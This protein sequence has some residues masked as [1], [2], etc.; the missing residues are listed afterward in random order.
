M[1]TAGIDMGAKTVKVVILKDGKV[2]AKSLV[3]AGREK[4]KYAQDAFDEALKQGGISS[5]DVQHITATGV[6]RKRVP[7]ANDDVTAVSADIKG[8]NSLVPSARTVIDV[9]AE[10]GRAIRC[11]AN[12]K[13]IDFAVNE[14]CAAGAGTFVETLARTMEI[15]LEDAGELSL[16]ST[17][18]IEM[19]AQCAVFGESEM[20]SLVHQKVPK[21][22]IIHAVHDAIASR[23]GSLV[24]TIEV[25][26]DI[27]VIGGVARN[28]GF[29][30]SLK[31][32]LGLDVIV[33][34][35]P[36]FAGALGAALIAA[37]GAPIE[38][39]DI[40]GKVV[41]RED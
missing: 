14:K 23:I 2:L 29:I 17:Q 41:A 10:E 3:V 16:K 9:G 27:A 34:E 18:S 25:E 26:K 7:F 36:E 5:K 15:K 6:G 32:N 40:E 8:V 13:L 1:I 31:K 35:E 24:R 21:V 39:G 11:D 22:D 33:P 20:V 4:E 37:S 28:V 38:E 12:G 19:N 30:D